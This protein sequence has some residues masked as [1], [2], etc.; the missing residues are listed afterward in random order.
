[1]NLEKLRDTYRS[2]LLDD[3]LPFWLKHG[4]DREN[5][6]Y[7]T[8]LDRDGSLLDSDKSVWVQG[9]FAWLLSAVNQFAGPNEERLNIAKSGLDFIEDHCID[10]ADGLMWFQVAANGRPIRKRRYRFSEAFACIAN[11]AYYQNTGEMG[12]AENAVRLFEVF[13]AHQKNP[14]LS[15]FAPKFTGTRPSKGIGAPM[16][17]INMAQICRAAGI[18]GVNWDAVIDENIAEIE[19][20]FVHRDI[21]CVMETV[22][23]DGT[24]IDDH[25]DGRTLNPGHAMEAAWFILHEA[26]LRGGDEKLIRLGTQMLDWMWARGWDEEFGGLLYFVGVDGRPVQEYWHDMKFW[27]PHNE[28]EIATLLAWQLTGEDRYARM[29]EQI[30][31]WTW[32]HFPDAEHGEWFGYL[33]RDGAVSS[34][35]KGNMWKGPFHIPRMLMTC[36]QICE[37]LL[38]DAQGPTQA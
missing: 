32:A 17:G 14:E 35:V 28:A 38:A 29:H 4:L 20:D 27:W 22:A 30:H 33:R 15:P 25:F 13:S 37:E 1:M 31:E 12:R 7:F 21:E 16:I 34:P 9:R 26:K 18:A 6:G 8:A 5:G 23:I 19:S 10:G 3:V 24:R 11:V 2:A 36:G